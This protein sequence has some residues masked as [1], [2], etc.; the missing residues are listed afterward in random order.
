MFKKILIMTVMLPLRVQAQQVESLG[1]LFDSLK[2]SPQSMVDDISLH[3]SLQGK[4]MANGLLYPTINLF[5]SYDYSSTPTGMIPIPPNELLDMVK[6]P[7]VAQPFSQ[8]ILRAGASIEMPIFVKSIYTMVAKSNAMYKSAE[9]MKYINLLKNE[10]LIVS[11]N[12]NLKYLN[13]MIASLNK[14]KKSILKTKEIIALKVKTERAPRSAL[15][16]IGNSLNQIDLTISVLETKKLEATSMIQTLTGIYLDSEVE[17]TQIGTFTNGSLVSLDPLRY[18]I[19]AEKLGMRAEK[20]K[21]Y[22]ALMLRGNYNYSMANAYN[23]DLAVNTNYSTV[24]IV[25]RVPIFEKS[26][27]AKVNA[28]KLDVYSLENDLNVKERE[29]NAQANQLQLTLKIIEKQGE[30]Y[31]QSIEDKKELLKIAQLS[32]KNGRMTIEDYLQYE[33]DLVLEQ[34]MFYKTEAEKWQALMKLAVIYGNNI[35]EIVK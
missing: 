11:L 9:Q 10:A 17:M 25:L 32:Y 7:S 1:V 20:E 8:S 29:L 30:L 23:N 3:K 6:D 4:K 5:G 33:D 28:K 13:Q 21:L 2:T 27:Y 22:P 34:S 18:K 26:Q 19:E 12:A 15:L 35:E 16:K 24:G 14:K 31:K